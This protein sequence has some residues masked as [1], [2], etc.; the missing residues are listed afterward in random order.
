MNSSVSPLIMKEGEVLL[1]KNISLNVIGKWEKRLGNCLFGNQIKSSEKILGLHMF[2]T[3]AG[4][5]YQLAA[6]STG[7]NTGIYKKVSTTLNGAITTA[8]T[9]IVLTSG[10]DFASSG[11]V[12]IEGDLITY[13]G[14]STHTLTGVTGI[15]FSHAT[16]TTVRQW[17]SIK[18]NDTDDK[19]TRFANFIDKVF[20]VNG[21]DV[22]SE[23]A[24][25]A[26]WNTTNCP[27]TITPSLIETYQ[28]RIFVAGDATLPDRLQASSTVNLAGTG[29]TWSTTT[30][31]IDTYGSNG[32][33]QDINP[34]DGD[35]IRALK[36]SG[37]LLLIF[38]D[39]NLYTWNGNSTEPD[40]LVDVGTPSQECVVNVHN[41]TF[42]IG[43]SKKFFGIYVFSGSYPKLISRKIKKWTDAITQT[44][45]DIGNMCIGADDTNVYAYVG[46]I[47]FTNDEVYGTRTFTDTWLVYNMPQDAWTIYTGLPARV[48]NNLVESSSEK[49]YFGN[50]DGKIFEVGSG[51]TDDSGDSQT[52]IEFEVIGKPDSLGDPTSTK[53]LQSVMVASEKAQGTSVKYRYDTSNDWQDLGTPEGKFCWIDAPQKN[54]KERFGNTLQLKFTNATK[55]TNSIL[56]CSLDV[57]DGEGLRK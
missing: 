51:Q 7:S 22:M 15:S 2:A 19:K 4:T 5:E 55:F 14:K 18:S 45:A 20:R 38:K 10:T 11:T 57:T 42:F 47:T 52:P 16:A 50:S 54:A 9:S 36:R 3:S 1:A 28:D 34:E 33:Y 12:E 56:G 53:T 17:K 46:T 27:S 35:Q 43:K 39:R 37:A 8:S 29:V 30:N 41:L 23:T 32:F 49:L 26:N 25:L 31:I 44:S 13:T 24:D 40:V 48:F 6:C 21:S